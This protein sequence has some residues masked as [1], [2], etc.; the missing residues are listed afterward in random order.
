MLYF[1]FICHTLKF[2]IM[3]SNSHSEGRVHL[4]VRVLICERFLK[5]HPLICKHAQCNTVTGK[6]EKTSGS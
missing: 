3:F 1:K 5:P 6:A 4:N 2:V